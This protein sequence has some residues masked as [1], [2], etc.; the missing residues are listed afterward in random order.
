MAFLQDSHPCASL[1]ALILVH[2]LARGCHVVRERHGQVT[3]I[4]EILAII[5]AKFADTEVDAVVER[6]ATMLELAGV[7]IE[8]TENLGKLKLAYDIDHIRYGTYI[9]FYADAVDVSVMKKV[10]Q[11]LRL[12]ED[13]LR[14][15]IVSHKD[16]IPARTPK[17]TSYVPPLTT[18]GRR[19]SE[20]QDDR[21]RAPKV[22]ALEEKPLSTQELDKKLDEILDSDIM[23]SI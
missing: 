8:K 12:S 4:Y 22:V 23:K 11:D 20:K 1:A 21:P 2:D 5:P 10:D 16:G 9:L 7:K 13:V 6:T 14:H 15:I 3:M 17:P 18:E 19:S